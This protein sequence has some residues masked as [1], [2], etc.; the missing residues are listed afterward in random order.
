MLNFI[1]WVLLASSLSIVLVLWR[2]SGMRKN[3]ESSFRDLIFRFSE[4]DSY[5]RFR[6][7]HPVVRFDQ[8]EEYIEKIKNGEKNVLC[9]GELK[10]LG[11]TSGTSGHIKELPMLPLQLTL[12]F[13]LGVVNT[14]YVM[15]QNFPGTY[16]L[17][18][19]LKIMFEPNMRFTKQG[20]MIGP[21]SHRPGERK[22]ALIVYSSPEEVFFLPTDYMQQAKYLHLLFA[23]R[24][25]NLGLIEAN[26][27]HMVHELMVLL[28]ASWKKLI[29]DIEHGKINASIEIP[30]DA[31]LKI[32]RKLKPLPERANFLK[33]EFE[34]GFQGIVGRIWPH[35]NLVLTCDT[36]AF[37]LYG[38]KLKE[39]Y[40]K[41]EKNGKIVPIFSPMYAATEGLLGVARVPFEKTYMHLPRSLFLEFISEN[42]FEKENP[43]AK[44]LKEIEV[45]KI[46]E[47]VVTTYS[48]LVRYRFGDVVKIVSF[49]NSLPV[50][51]FQY[52][53]GQVMDLKGEKTAEIAIFR[54]IETTLQCHQLV[55]RLVDY[56]CV[57]HTYINCE[58]IR[59]HIFME[60]DGNF[61][62]TS[63][64]KEIAT[65]LDQELSSTNE[66]YGYHRYQINSI[67]KL[68][69]HFLNSGTFKELAS[70]ISSLGGGN[71]NQIKIPRYLKRQELI[72]FVLKKEIE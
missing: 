40:L 71:I 6:R 27:A 5:E 3:S 28:E 55:G 49:Y 11:T 4:I 62:E 19:S 65:T 13:Q 69:L 35:L 14:F 58:K 70:L 23:L 48:G 46:Y 1:L 2:I 38:I 56:T 25:E 30:A 66:G 50:M 26:F 33:I 60:L 43:N 15:F 52:R 54:A 51:E 10:Q 47:L 18:K 34:K 32:E 57:H 31:K 8:F 36:G 42:D 64:K 21:L 44:S 63:K 37:E 24:D 68:K 39:K 9:A 20:L 45:G 41:P 22:S 29:Q 16:S 12:F 7:A 53:Q 17:Q 72:D 61:S 67:G 59:Y